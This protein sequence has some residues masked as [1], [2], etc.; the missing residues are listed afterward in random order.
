MNHHSKIKQGVKDRK[1]DKYV[2]RVVAKHRKDGRSES[3]CQK[4]REDEYIKKEMSRIHQ[5]LLEPQLEVSERFK[6]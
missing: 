5:E 2:E 3:D 4:I 6:K 1:F